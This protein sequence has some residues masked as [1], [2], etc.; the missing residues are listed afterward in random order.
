M[1]LGVALIISALSPYI[2]LVLRTCLYNKGR[3]PIVAQMSATLLARFIRCSLFPVPVTSSVTSPSDLIF[4]LLAIHFNIFVAGFSKY[5]PMSLYVLNLLANR[6][7][8][9]GE[10]ELLFCTVINSLTFLPPN[11]LKKDCK[12]SI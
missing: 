8:F 10:K 12:F 1:P 7:A 11:I 5:H 3:S 2:P 9:I 4:S 6:S